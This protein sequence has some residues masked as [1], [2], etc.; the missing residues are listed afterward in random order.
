MPPHPTF[1]CRREVVQSV[2][3]FDLDYRIAADYDFMLRALELGDF[4]AAHIPSVLVDMARRRPQ[5]R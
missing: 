3:G 2:G 4:S 1:Y 5:F